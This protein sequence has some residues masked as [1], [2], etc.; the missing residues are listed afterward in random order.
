MAESP[1]GS[2]YAR[3]RD[4]LA[5]A[6]VL[7][8]FTAVLVVV[9]VQAWPPAPVTAPDGRTEIP[10]RSTTVRLP[11]WSPSLSREASLFVVVM[12]AGALG[13]V[14]HVLRSFYWYVGNRALR[15]SWLMM[16]LLL[17]FVGALFAL[18]VYLVLRGGLTSPAGGAADINPY[19]MA[20]IA[21]LVGLFS[22]ETAEKLRTVFG[23]LLAPA[24]PGR[25][26]A[27]A[28]RITL[29]EPVSGPPG[30]AV[31]VHGSGLA[32]ATGARFGPA[33]APVTDVTDTRLRTTVPT[34]AASGC[35]IVYTPAGGTASPEPFTV[36]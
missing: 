23:T 5:V 31:T 13:G 4:V 15:R 7:L 30:T 8:A 35:L 34:G 10:V 20:A 19:G 24:P 3:T 27:L 26:Q 6:A 22:R 2:Q 36:E 25:D 14:V 9:L 32:A 17:P 11:G 1:V 21:A 16:Y 28:P 29:V 33:R 12:T 18:I